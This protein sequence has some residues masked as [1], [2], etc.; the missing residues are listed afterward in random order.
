MQIDHHQRV[1]VSEYGVVNVLLPKTIPVPKIQAAWER[2]IAAETFLRDARLA[3]DRTADA[4]TEAKNNDSIRAVELAEKG[5]IDPEPRRLT[6]VAEAAHKDA[7]ANVE[8]A[9]NALLRIYAEF[10]DAVVENRKAWIKN[11]RAGAEASRDAVAGAL[12]TL[13]AESKNLH[14]HLGAL[15]LLEAETLPTALHVSWSLGAP[16][17]S[18]GIEQIDQA[19]VLIH[20]RIEGR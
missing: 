13:E 17:L 16:E 14:G 6:I 4:L 18:T 1:S 9:K 15:E 19:L 8:P 20:R 10:R 3:R 11:A 12:R 5:E 7:V 2:L